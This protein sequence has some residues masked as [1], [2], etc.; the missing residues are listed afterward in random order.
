MW[1]KRSIWLNLTADHIITNTRCSEKHECSV[2]WSSVWGT[3]LNLDIP[4]MKRVGRGVI[5]ECTLN[6]QFSPSHF[7]TSAGTIVHGFDFT[8][9]A[10]LLGW[11]FR[12]RIP[13]LGR[14]GIR[15]S[16]SEFRIPELSGGKSNRKTWKP[17]KSKIGIPVPIFP[18]F[19]NSVNY[20]HRNSVYSNIIVLFT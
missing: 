5:S 17:F 12:F 3:C 18:E 15:N 16:D 9:Q 20:I 10:V 7:H 13:I 4:Y 2:S 8:N 6:V 14:A 19:R 1:N 11:E